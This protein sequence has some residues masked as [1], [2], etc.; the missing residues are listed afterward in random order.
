[1]LNSFFVDVS[2]TILV[3]NCQLINSI[4]VDSQYRY[5]IV[6]RKQLVNIII[7]LLNIEL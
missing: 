3:H 6:K 2:T 1:M 5:P 4:E 7:R